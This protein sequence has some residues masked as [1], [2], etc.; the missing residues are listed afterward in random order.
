M[1]EDLREKWMDESSV[2]LR[3]IFEFCIIIM[4]II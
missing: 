4:K 3:D 2:F 1:E